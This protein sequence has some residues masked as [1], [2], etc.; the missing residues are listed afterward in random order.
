MT[1][2]MHTATQ[3]VQHLRANGF[4]AHDAVPR[5]V[6]NLVEEAGEFVGAYRRWAGMAR[7]R[8]TVEDVHAEL[9]DVVITAYVTAA[10]L[11]TNVDATLADWRREGSQP[12]WLPTDMPAGLETLQRVLMVSVVVAQTAP[13]LLNG[14]SAWTPATMLTRVIRAADLAAGALAFDLDAA[15]TAKLAVIFSRGW[16]EPAESSADD[17]PHTVP[18]GFDCGYLA[19]SEADLDS[20]EAACDHHPDTGIAGEQPAPRAMATVRGTHPRPGHAAVADAWA[21]QAGAV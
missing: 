11:G 15:I 12:Y 10:E 5:Q 14:R 8:G 3:I 9:A 20:H 4:S 19:A 18:C 17:P 7:R 21:E 6:L 2:N 1:I 16:R 13:D